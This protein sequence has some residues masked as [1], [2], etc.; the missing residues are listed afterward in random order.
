MHGVVCHVCALP[1]ASRQ[2]CLYLVNSQC[3]WRVSGNSVPAGGWG[4][5]ASGRS[6]LRIKRAAARA[7]AGPWESIVARPGRGWTQTRGTAF[8]NVF[9]RTKPAPSLTE[10]VHFGALLF[11]SQH[12]NCQYKTREGMVGKV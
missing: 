12:F 9:G 1:T 2:F 3:T 4:L 8:S 11:F 10:K 5:P 6:G 7:C